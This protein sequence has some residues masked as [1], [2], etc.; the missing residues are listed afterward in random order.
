MNQLLLLLVVFRFQ[1][2]LLFF[3]VLRLLLLLSLV[4]AVVRVDFHSIRH[5]GF[6]FESWTTNEDA[7]LLNEIVSEVGDRTKQKQTND[8]SC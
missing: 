8:D 4:V 3:R 1:L 5:D 2:V 7:N 6:L